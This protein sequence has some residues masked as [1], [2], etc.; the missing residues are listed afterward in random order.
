MFGP[1]AVAFETLRHWASPHTGIGYPVEW[2][3]HVGPRQFHLQ[4]LMDDGELDGRRS[5][6]AVYGEGAVRFAE[7]GHEVRRGHLEMTRDG[8]RIGVG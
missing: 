5:T 2:R 7:D 1:Q 4:P 8:E 3:V 6:G